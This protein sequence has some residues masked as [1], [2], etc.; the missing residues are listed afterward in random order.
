MADNSSDNQMTPKFLFVIGSP[1]SGTSWIQKS[2]A[3]QLGWVTVPELH[4]ATEVLRPVLNAWKRRTD[5]L[6]RALA[7]LERTGRQAGRLIGMPA[8]LEYYELVRALRSPFESLVVRASATYGPIDVFVEKTPGNSVLTS[9]IGQVFP[10]AYMLHVLRDPRTMV[11]SM[12][13]AGRGEWTGGWA[14]RS[15]IVA[16]LMWRAYV[17]GARRGRAHAQY[18]EVKYEDARRSLP[19]EMARIRR[20]LDMD[21]ET[22]EPGSFADAR[23]ERHE[24]VSSRVAEVVGAGA[25]GEPEGFGDGSVSRPELS[26]REIWLVETVTAKLMEECGYVARYPSARWVN[27]RVE[28]IASLLMARLP[29]S[30]KEDL[31][32]NLRRLRLFSWARDRVRRSHERRAER[33]K[34][35]SRQ[36]GVSRKRGSRMAPPE[37]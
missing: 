37:A 6:E 24:I 4:Y 12:R 23:P 20:W 30:R 17:A 36:L 8:S 35:R 16:A 1:R 15:V 26:S 21:P 19:A 9:Y 34:C 31:A 13:T 14:P 29:S 10:E 25:V 11:R 5:A 3:E 32:L 22:G 18:L 27:R 28:M 33:V 2:L 7:P